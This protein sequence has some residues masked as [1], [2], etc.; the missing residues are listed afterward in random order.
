MH[1]SRE[2]ELKM[3]DSGTNAT[4]L[5]L[6]IKIEDEIF[7]YKLFDERD[8]FPFFIVRMPPSESNIPST[9]V[10]GST[11]SDFLRISRCTLK[12]DHF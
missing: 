12:L 9:V 8:Q 5:D 7:V 3:E 4:F 6:D 2:L 11:F 10:W 1:V